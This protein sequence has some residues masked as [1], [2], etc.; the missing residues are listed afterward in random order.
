[1]QQYLDDGTQV[2]DLKIGFTDEQQKNFASD[3]KANVQMLDMMTV[4]M[5]IVGFVGGVLCSSP[6]RCCC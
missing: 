1:M 5:P 3:T 2:V 6:A 4:W